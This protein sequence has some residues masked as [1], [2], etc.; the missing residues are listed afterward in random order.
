M[1]YDL[2]DSVARILGTQS[3]STCKIQYIFGLTNANKDTRPP[4][5]MNLIR[6]LIKSTEIFY[7]SGVD[8]DAGGTTGLA[9][10]L[11]WTQ[12]QLFSGDFTELGPGLIDVI[13]PF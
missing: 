8:D 2:I 13:A 7:F 5:S 10:N 1:K 11:Y 12:D 6:K 3:R 4:D 9:S